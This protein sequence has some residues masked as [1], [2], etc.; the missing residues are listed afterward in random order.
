MTTPSWNLPR[1]VARRARRVPDQ[2]RARFSTPRELR[3]AAKQAHEAH[4]FM[5]SEGISATWSNAVVVHAARARG[6]QVSGDQ[7]GRV[8]LSDGHRTRYFDDGVANINSRMA[9]RVVQN[10]QVTSRLLRARRIRTPQSEVFGPDETHKAWAWAE[11]LTPLTLLDP[12]AATRRKSNVP[13]DDRATFVTSFKRMAQAHPQ[14]MVEELVAGVTH[15]V[16]MVDGAVVAVS[17]LLPAHVVG[18]GRLDVASLVTAKN[19]ARTASPNPIH[20]RIRLNAAARRELARQGLEPTS[21]PKP[22][23]VVLLR[24]SPGPRFGGDAIDAT[25]ELSAAEVQ[26]IESA[27]R[28][29]RGLRICRIDVALPRDGQGAEPYVIEVNEAADLATHHF[30][31]QGQ[32]RPAAG[33]VLHAMLPD[34]APPPS[35]PTSS[36]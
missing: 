21:V 15:R 33:A 1:R 25:S 5:T 18:N 20:G 24:S 28:A 30:P 36:R 29:F 23:Q 12:E 16:L 7:R 14:V 2:V 8:R 34:S 27:A 6:L 4:A 26:F 9:R 22:G 19:R 10:R 3:I 35:T 17:R 32:V 11:T 13:I 31:W